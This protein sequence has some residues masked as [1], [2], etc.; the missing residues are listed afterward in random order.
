ME[1]F[2]LALGLQALSFLT[3]FV[4]DYLSQCKAVESAADGD[5]GGFEGGSGFELKA[6]ASRAGTR[7]SMSMRGVRRF[8]RGVRMDGRME[9]VGGGGIS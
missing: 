4:A 2:L 8:M 6:I 7:M 5:G 9:D 1:P 3:A